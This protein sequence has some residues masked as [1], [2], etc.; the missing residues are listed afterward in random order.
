MTLQKAYQL[1]GVSEPLALHRAYC[2]LEQPLFKDKTW[3]YENPEQTHNQIKRELEELDLDS[4]SENEREW[5][6]EILW[7]WHH[8]AI[9]CAVWK[10][11]KRAA[12]LHASE[13]L[14]YQGVDHPNK[15]TCLLF[16][17][18]HDEREQAEQWAETIA[19]EV[20]GPTAQ[21]V[22]GWFAEDEIF[23]SPL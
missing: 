12:R 11:D 7:C 5:C 8:H 18:V 2:E 14:Q 9:S 22:L 20:E 17:L 1:A 16:L 6:R 13:A 4:L 23:G 3:D 21:A 15:I 10:R 19:D